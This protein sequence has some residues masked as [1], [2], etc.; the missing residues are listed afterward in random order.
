MSGL[1]AAHLIRHALGVRSAAP[2]RAML[3]IALLCGTP[4]LAAAQLL[5]DTNCDGR[6]D[7]HDRASLAAGLFWPS[8]VPCAGADVN[9]DGA[10]S[11]ADLIAYALG[12]RVSYIGLASPDGR[13]APSLGTLEDGAPVF[14]RNSGFGF[15]LVVEAAPPPNGALI[16]TTTFDMLP[17][18]PLRRPDLQIVADRNLGNGSR[19]VCDEFGIPALDPLA[20]DFTQ[21][22]SN[23]I[24]DFSCRFNAATRRSA[25]CTQDAFGQPG[26]VAETSRVQFCA[27]VNAQ[28]AFGDGETRLSVQIRDSSGMVGPLQQLVVRVGSGPQPPTFTPQPPTPTWT[29]TPTDS[30]TALPTLTHSATGTRTDTRTPTRPRTATA[31]RTAAA[32]QTPTHTATRTGAATPTRTATGPTPTVTR[33]PTRGTPATATRT[34]TRTAT[35]PTR[36]ATRTPSG[37]TPTRTRT[38]SGATAT[39]T[40]TRTPTRTVGG[41]TATRTPTGTA[42]QGGTTPSPTRTRTPTAAIADRGPVITYLGV[43]RADDMLITPIGMAGNVPIYRSLFGYG[44]SLIVEAKPGDSRARVGSASFA[45]GGAPDL[46][47][48]VSRPLGNGS[49]DVCDDT[50]P[51]LGGVPA[52]NPPDFSTSPAIADRL[53]DLGCRFIDGSNNKQGRACSDFTAC[54]LRSDGQFGCA[55]SDTALQF[56]GFMSQNLAFP[57]GDTTVTARVR[58]VQ[59]NL[60]PARQ[61]IIRVP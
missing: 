50:P 17:N 4:P 10:V 12:P 35:G 25:T 20:F 55:A 7:E 56:C 15:L 13:L 60:G 58:D 41:A 43:T 19:D 5:R 26:F 27:P 30:P 37:A 34:A 3:A 22:V 47:V 21:A 48:Q 11:A 42:T 18:D 9:R 39:R 24:N 57:S 38:P 54:V 6:V 44:F 31:T 51:I 28:M 45:V 53:N 59:G 1:K 2:A 46:Q 16:G 14:F 49:A 61:I 52:I 33:T 29:A 23:T 32:G 36:T 40:V 8:E